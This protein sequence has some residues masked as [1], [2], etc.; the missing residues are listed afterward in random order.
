MMAAGDVPRRP[1]GSMFPPPAT[2]A[3]IR[4]AAWAIVRDQRAMAA[5]G[6]GRA[7]GWAR[8]FLGLDVRT[9]ATP[10]GP[11]SFVPDEPA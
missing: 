1:D 9:V 5:E 8:A 4:D 7:V 10:A 11:E 3:E 2:L 6:H